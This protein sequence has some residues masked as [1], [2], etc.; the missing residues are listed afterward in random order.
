[1]RP[2]L[3][4]G[5]AL[6]LAT[7]VGPARGQVPPDSA[8]PEPPPPPP[9]G[10]WQAWAAVPHPWCTVVAL[11]VVL[12]TGG[13]EDPPGRSGTARLLG[14][15]SADAVRQRLGEDGLRVE[16]RVDRGRTVYRVL[17]VPEAWNRAYGALE[18]VLFTGPTPSEGLAEERASLQAELTFE[19][20]SPVREFEGELYRMLSGAGA[21]TWSRDPRG[22]VASLDSITPADLGTYRR[23]HYDRGRAVLSVVGA[24]DPDEVSRT[25]VGRMADGAPEAGEHGA[26]VAARETPPGPAGP[27]WAEADRIRLVRDVTSGWIGAAYPVDPSV[28]RTAVEMLLQRAR[29]ELITNPP[30]PGLFSAEVALQELPGGESVILIRAAVLPD[31][32]DRWETRIL[33]TMARVSAERLQP[34]FFRFHRRRFRNLR[35]TEDASPEVEGL[36]AALDLRRDGRLRDLGADI[37]GLDSDALAGAAATLGPPRVLVF[38]PDL[39]DG[40]G[41]ESPTREEP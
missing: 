29:S 1:M 13:A 18:S 5:L 2:A 6:L 20:G 17:A 24:V 10:G 8:P 40:S 4:G 11:T 19:A 16:A 25:V 22:T 35:L 28:P 7:A 3:L 26:M 31:A 32:V 15:L 9:T 21:T 30:A 36:R 12:P 14:E 38:G 34:D 23:R 41:G 27:A 37:W 39:A 33:D